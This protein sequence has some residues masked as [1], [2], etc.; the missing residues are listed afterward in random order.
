MPSEHLSFESLKL[1]RQFLNAVDDLEYT[2]PTA[3]QLKAIPLGLAGHDILG[4]AQTGTG[5]TA[6][7]ML[8]ILMKLKY[9]QGDSPRALVLAPTRE[10]VIQIEE[11]AKALAKYTDLR[12]ISLY[13]GLGPKQQ[14]ELVGQ[15]SVIRGD[16]F[17]L[18]MLLQNLLSNASKYSPEKS[19]IEVLLKEQDNLVSIRVEDSGPSIEESEYQ[20]VFERFYRIS[21]NQHSSNTPG[22][23]LGLAI[24]KHIAEL[25]NASLKLGRSKRLFGLSVELQLPQ[26]QTSE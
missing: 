5:K 2:E 26:G 7:F 24:S 16:K 22:C 12:I 25:H 9:A 23:G 21:S 19:K 6:A 20:K 8:P 4:I 1:T 10:L 15:G 18:S 13:G 11:S 17:S 3:I 14:I